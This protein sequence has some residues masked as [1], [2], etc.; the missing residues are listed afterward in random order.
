MKRFFTLLVFSA[1]L[2]VTFASPK[3]I[4]PNGEKQSIVLKIENIDNTSRNLL[5]HSI[6]FQKYNRVQYAAILSKEF[7]IKKMTDTYDDLISVN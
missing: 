7:T 6:A 5:I 4:N 1:L 2:V 3:S